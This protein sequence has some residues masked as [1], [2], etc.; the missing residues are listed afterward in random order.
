MGVVLS[1]VFRHHNLNIW[2]N[3]RICI[4]TGSEDDEA[5]AKRLE[6]SEA[7]H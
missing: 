1:S 2:V 7:S 3:N 4:E 5:R 6:A